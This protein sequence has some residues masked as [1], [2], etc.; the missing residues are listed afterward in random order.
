M[1]TTL[2]STLSLASS[3]CASIPNCTSE[4]LAIIIA[5]GVF[6][7]RIDII[8]PPF[9]ASLDEPSNCGRF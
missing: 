3:A 1:L 4:P 5:S 6:F 7:L 8:Y 9:S 2:T